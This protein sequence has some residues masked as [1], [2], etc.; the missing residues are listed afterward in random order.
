LDDDEP[1][2][3]EIIDTAGQ[4][5]YQVL[6]DSWFRQSDCFIF[7]YDISDKESLTEIGKIITK[8]KQ[9]KENE[10]SI[11][12]I[13]FIPSVLVGCKLDLE[14]KID[15][16]TAN[17]FAISSLFIDEEPDD[18]FKF[19]VET[20]AKGKVFFCLISKM[21]RILIVHFNLF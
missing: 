14:R 15:Q 21:E 4:D 10:I 17:A 12:S 18:E 20:S 6:L 5:Q 7:C 1:L 19:F 8:A 2:L 13:P 11:P 3:V 16:E 9:A